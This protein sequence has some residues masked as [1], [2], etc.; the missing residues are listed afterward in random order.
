MILTGTVTPGFVLQSPA[1]QD[2]AALPP[3]F[4]CAVTGQ[5]GSGD[6]PPL[7]WS[8][9]P[10]AT[11]AFALFEQDM[12]V[13]PPNGPVVHW[14]IYNI[15]AT[16]STLERGLAQDPTLP[17]GALQGINSRRTPGY[18]GA[19]PPPG[20]AAHHYVFQ[21]FALDAPLNVKA[22]PTIIDLQPAMQGHVLAQT[23]LR[24]TFGR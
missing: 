23:Q 15:P 24:A 21:F 16:L 3:E 5:A 11:K 18:L 9:A 1:F 19:C 22:Q 2:N 8:G 14:I 7:G 10:A 4:S 13:P 17:N 12:D 20:A 6:S